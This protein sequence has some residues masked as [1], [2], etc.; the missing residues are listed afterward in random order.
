MYAAAH[1]ESNEPRKSFVV[2]AVKLSLNA[3]S[4]ISYEH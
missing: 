1:I 3:I 2:D 4:D